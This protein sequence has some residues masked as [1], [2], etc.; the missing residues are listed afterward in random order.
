MDR[1][2]HYVVARDKNGKV[3]LLEDGTAKLNYEPLA[4]VF[5]YYDDVLIATKWIKD[6]ETSKLEHFKVVEEV[7]KRLS[8]HQ[9]KISINKCS[10]FSSSIKFLGWEITRDFIRVDPDRVKKIL[11]RKF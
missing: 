3:I 10:F 5:L 9:S 6:Y 1:M 8:E 2:I 7:V 11:R 4:D